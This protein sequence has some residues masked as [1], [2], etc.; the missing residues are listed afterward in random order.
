M[1]KL[2]SKKEYM[3]T[4]DVVLK[5]LETGTEDICFDDSD[6]IGLEFKDF[7]FMEVGKNYDCK[8]KLFGDP[9]ESPYA[10]K[11]LCRVVDD[12]VPCGTRHLVQVRVGK[13]IYYV[14]RSHVENQLSNGS[15]FYYYTRKD[16]IQVDDVVHG[17]YM[18]DWTAWKSLDSQ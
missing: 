14:P 12:N 5:N 17:D 9:T 16:L 10:Q 4:R 3:A 2:L 18:I 8:I 11:A 6:V 1:Y 13:D 7:Y 15:F